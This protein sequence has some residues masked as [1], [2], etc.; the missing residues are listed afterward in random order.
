MYCQVRHS[1]LRDKH[2]LLEAVEHRKWREEQRPPVAE[3]TLEVQVLHKW[4]LASVGPAKLAAAEVGRV[5]GGC[6]WWLDSGSWLGSE[7]VEE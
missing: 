2:S 3:D 5:A 7:A 6:G 4:W 1:L